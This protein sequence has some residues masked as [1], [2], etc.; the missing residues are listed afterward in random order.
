MEDYD[1]S[2]EIA[3]RTAEKKI[4]LKKKNI[5]RVCEKLRRDT[6]LFEDYLKKYAI[7]TPQQN[8]FEMRKILVALQKKLFVLQLGIK[9]FQEARYEIKKVSEW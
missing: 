9:E 3:L 7:Y 6:E 8:L 1:F 4:G 5:S 2:K